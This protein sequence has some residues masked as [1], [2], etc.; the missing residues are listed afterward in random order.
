MNRPSLALLALVLSLPMAA[1]AADA[2]GSI[3][4]PALPDVTVLTESGARVRFRDLIA[5]RTVAI[6]FIF[7]SC[8]TVC[9]LMGA[10]FG[11]VQKL[12]GGRAVTLVSVSVDPETDTPARLAAWGQRFGASSGWTLVTGTKE[13]INRILKAFGVFTADPVSHSPTAFVADTRRGLW[14]KVDGLAPPSTI[15]Q[16]IDGV[17]AEERP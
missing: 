1:A 8:P 6:N 10:S 15:V 16:M 13:D 3:P 4:P 2:P 7:T 5:G 11:R 9:P 14:R 17:L 12:L